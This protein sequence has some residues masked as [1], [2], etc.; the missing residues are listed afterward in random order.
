LNLRQY[1][2]ISAAGAPSHFLVGGKIFGGKLGH[3]NS[4][5]KNAKKSRAKLRDMAMMP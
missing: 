5:H 1:G 2:I 4:A 3:C